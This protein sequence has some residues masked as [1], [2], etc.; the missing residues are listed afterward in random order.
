[1]DLLVIVI[2]MMAFYVQMFYDLQTC[3]RCANGRVH[4]FPH[5]CHKSSL[6]RWGLSRIT[7]Q[8]CRP[9]ISQLGRGHGG[10]SWSQVFSQ[11]AERNPGAQLPLLLL[12]ESGTSARHRDT[13]FQ[14][15]CSSSISLETPCAGYRDDSLIN[16]ESPEW[17]EP[18]LRTCLHSIRM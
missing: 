1:M 11:E 3:I 9:C 7:G 2:L 4:C 14:G 18:H 6:G 13:H 17:G 15:G 16:L 12:I 8:G 10:R 5:C